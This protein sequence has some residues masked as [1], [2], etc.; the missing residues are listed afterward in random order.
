[1]QINATSYIMA[2]FDY[3]KD[4]NIPI[5]VY[6]YFPITYT[7]LA[8]TSYSKFSSCSINFSKADECDAISPSVSKTSEWHLHAY[9]K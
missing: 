1:M 6:F 2:I 8:K 7:E 5:N 3:S 4:T 9:T